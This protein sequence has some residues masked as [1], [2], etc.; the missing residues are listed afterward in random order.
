MPLH[1]QFALHKAVSSWQHPEYLPYMMER[2]AFA[3]II[4]IV[5]L[6]PIGRTPRSLFK[7]ISLL[8]KRGLC[9]L[10]GHNNYTDVW[11]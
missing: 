9:S 1:L 2:I 4:L 3:I 8:A 5:S 11:L 6:I 10:D 7:A